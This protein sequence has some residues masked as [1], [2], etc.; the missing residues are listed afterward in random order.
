MS[1]DVQ[2]Q[3]NIEVGEMIAYPCASCAFITEMRRTN[4]GCQCL[5]IYI[6]ISRIFVMIIDIQ[7]AMHNQ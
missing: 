6:T 5:P 4:N 7:P 2:S 3:N 1:H